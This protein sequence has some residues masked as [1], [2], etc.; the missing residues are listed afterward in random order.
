MRTLAWCALFSAFFSP[1]ASALQPCHPDSYREDPNRSS[2]EWRKLASWVAV[3][4]V[5][6]RK[7]RK[8][9]YP[10]CALK[11]TSQCAQWDRSELRIKVERYEKGEGPRDLVLV[12]EYCA[13]DPPAQAGGRF[14]FYG[15]SLSAYVMYEAAGGKA[16]R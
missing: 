3:G 13:P 8:I 14:R 10:N 5:A 7:E 4:V 11:D 15:Q 9:P 2:A 1:R 6:G 12:A 16:H